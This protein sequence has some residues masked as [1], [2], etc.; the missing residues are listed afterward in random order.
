VPFIHDIKDVLVAA[1]VGTFTGSNI[2]IFIGSKAEIPAGD[3]P[4]IV[5]IET[6]GSGSSRTQGGSS[7][8]HPSAQ[9]SVRATTSPVARDKLLEIRDVLGGDN[10]LY[11][12]VLSGNRYISIIP[13]QSVTDIGEDEVGR[14]RFAYNIQAERY[15]PSA[16]LP[17]IQMDWVQQ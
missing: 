9:I 11:N 13:N 2:N 15:A 5:L 12:I 10:G 17:W 14:P 1:G 3:G 8:E 7:T 4:F 16:A 6:G